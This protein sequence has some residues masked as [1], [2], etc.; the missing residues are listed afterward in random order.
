MA[1][2]WTGRLRGMQDG[3]SEEKWLQHGHLK[4]RWSVMDARA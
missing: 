1:A 3:G 4:E 2:G